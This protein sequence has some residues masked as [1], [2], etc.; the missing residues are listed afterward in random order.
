MYNKQ[1]EEIFCF[2]TDSW[3]DLKDSFENQFSEV[4][5]NQE[6]NMGNI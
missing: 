6:E 3:V 1:L 4:D 5:K 2:G